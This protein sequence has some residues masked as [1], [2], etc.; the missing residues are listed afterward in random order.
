MI[1]N[2]SNAS[3]LLAKSRACDNVILSIAFT[4]RYD[5]LFYAKVILKK[6]TC[7]KIIPKK[8]LLQKQMN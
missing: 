7:K 3:A 1:L 6:I 8:S 2:R 4:A 5:T